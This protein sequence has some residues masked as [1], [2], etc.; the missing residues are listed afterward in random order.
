MREPS[1]ERGFSIRQLQQPAIDHSDL[2]LELSDRR[3]Q[4]T[5]LIS[6]LKHS[7]LTLQSHR[8]EPLATSKRNVNVDDLLYH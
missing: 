1:G 7:L 8:L 3:T 2:V 5:G 4:F 6:E